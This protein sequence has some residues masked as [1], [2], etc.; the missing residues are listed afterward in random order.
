LS[1]SQ[2]VQVPPLILKYHLT[3]HTAE[4]KVSP[5]KQHV[6]E[7]AGFD[8]SITAVTVDDSPNSMVIV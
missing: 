2:A 8:A 3:L 6:A 1:W 5:E 4:A 7:R